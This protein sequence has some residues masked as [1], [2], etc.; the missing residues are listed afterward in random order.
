[1]RN[2]HLILLGKPEGRR[3]LRR[4]RHRWKNRIKLDLTETRWAGMDWIDQWQPLVNRVI[5][6]RVPKKCWEIFE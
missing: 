1:M 2:G 6:L 4:P 3:P 5:N